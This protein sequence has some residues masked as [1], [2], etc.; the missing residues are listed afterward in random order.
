M[1][2][3][4]IQLVMLKSATSGKLA[5]LQ[6]TI[7]FAGKNRPK[8]YMVDI[9]TAGAGTWGGSGYIDAKDQITFK[10]VP[11]GRYVLQGHPNPTTPRQRTDPK[12]VELKSGKVVKISFLA[13]KMSLFDRWRY[14]WLQRHP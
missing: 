3:G 7:D 11:P 4:G 6:V 14:I 8:Q 1:P 12:I 9:S 5:T 10:N 13:N 2:A